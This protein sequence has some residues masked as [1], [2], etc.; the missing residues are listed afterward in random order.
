MTV[1]IT[2]GLVG[3]RIKVRWP[4]IT[5]TGEQQVLLH[6]QVTGEVEDLNLW[7]EFRPEIERMVGERIGTG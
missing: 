6:R 4:R 1:R 3:D 2:E 7:L 5:A